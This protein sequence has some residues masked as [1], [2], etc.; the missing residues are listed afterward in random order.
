MF[1]MYS[2]EERPSP[3]GAIPTCA[4]SVLSPLLLVRDRRVGV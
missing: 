4:S 2:A 1:D 3:P